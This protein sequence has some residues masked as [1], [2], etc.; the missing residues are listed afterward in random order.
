MFTVLRV[1]LVVAFELWLVV[2][3]LVYCVVVRC[4]LSLLVF[5]FVVVVC[6]R[7]VCSSMCV[8]GCWLLALG[9]C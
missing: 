6:A 1:L 9:R 7:G 5:F 2:C 4:C 3:F 8:V